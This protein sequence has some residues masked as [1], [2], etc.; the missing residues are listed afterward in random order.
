VGTAWC[1]FQAAVWSGLSQRYVNQS[2]AAKFEKPWIRRAMLL[3][4]LAAFL[5]AVGR[6]CLLPAQL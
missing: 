3:F 4:G 1:S 6:L 5:F 2:A